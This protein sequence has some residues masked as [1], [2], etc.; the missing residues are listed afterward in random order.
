MALKLNLNNKMKHL[1]E[2][3]YSNKAIKHA[4][5]QLDNCC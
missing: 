3:H 4:R 5:V 1:K 2:K